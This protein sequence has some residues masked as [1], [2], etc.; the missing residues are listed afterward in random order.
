MLGSPS[1]GAK[2]S[3]L[4]LSVKF[5]GIIVAD[6]AELQNKFCQGG[7]TL[8]AEKFP[9]QLKTD[10]ENTSWLPYSAYLCLD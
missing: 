2:T 8:Q 7:G 10:W 3:Y 9:L 5:P 4:A 6:F 1:N